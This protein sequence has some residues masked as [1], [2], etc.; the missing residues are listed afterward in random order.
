MEGR[1]RTEGEGPERAGGKEAGPGASGGFES[2]LASVPSSYLWAFVSLPRP[3]GWES[4]PNPLPKAER[5]PAVNVSSL[6]IVG[7]RKLRPTLKWRLSPAAPGAAQRVFRRFCPR[8]GEQ[9]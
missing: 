2:C 7:W 3:S 4:P 1:K 9:N 6:P 8:A 5:A